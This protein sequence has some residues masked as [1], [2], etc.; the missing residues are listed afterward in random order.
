MT[1]L[2]RTEDRVKGAEAGADDFLTKPPDEQELLTRIKSLVRIKFLHDALEASN[3][4]LAGCCTSGP[5]NWR[6]QP[7]EL[8]KTAGGKGAFQPQ[9]DPGISRLT[10]DARG[11]IRTAPVAE[12]ERLGEVDEKPCATSSS[13]C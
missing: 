7:Q 9:S 2:A 8:Q 1:A 10:A 4:Q 5:S 12:K 3:H 13:A 11:P 6:R